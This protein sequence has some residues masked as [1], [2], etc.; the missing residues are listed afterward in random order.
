MPVPD[1]SMPVTDAPALAPALD[2]PAPVDELCKKRRVRATSEEEDE[3]EK[4]MEVEEEKKEL[5]DLLQIEVDRVEVHWRRW[6]RHTRSA[7]ACRSR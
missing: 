4:V 7:R 5:F 6:W 2:A 3:P 1:D